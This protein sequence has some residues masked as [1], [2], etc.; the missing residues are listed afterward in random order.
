MPADGR[1]GG[2]IVQGHVDGTGDDHRPHARR[3]LGGRRDRAAGRSCARVRRREGLDH[4]RRRLA[5]RRRRR[6]TTWFA[7]SLIPDDARRAPR[8]APGSPATGST[9][10]STSSPSTSSACSSDSSTEDASGASTTRAPRPRSSARS[11]TS[12]AGKA[13]RRRRRRGPR[14][15]GR[16]HPR[17]R[18]GHARAGWRS[19]SATPRG[20]ICAPMPAE[21][22]RPARAAADGRRTTATHAHRLHGLGRRRATAS[23]PASRAAD[24]ARTVP[25]ARRLG[26][27]RRATSSGP[28]HVLPLR[29]AAG[30]RAG[31]RR[32]H[33]GRRRPGPARRPRPRPA[34][35]AR[36]STTTAR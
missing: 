7:V 26:D 32:P 29:A 27:R 5:H 34:S 20:C 9:S 18:A 16:P 24:R 1:L 21:I 6:P 25:G 2:H 36:S 14:E 15:R 22:A 19:R 23:P 8:S 17:R 31:A 3:A 28:G 33:R 4:R 13:G 12:A 10:R 35:S 30:R 11:R